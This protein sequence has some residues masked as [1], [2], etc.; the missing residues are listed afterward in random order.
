M[1]KINIPKINLRHTKKQSPH[2]TCL[3]NLNHYIKTLTWQCFTHL[4]DYIQTK[5]KHPY[6]SPIYYE[7]TNNWIQ[8][9]RLKTYQEAITNYHEKKSTIQSKYKLKHTKKQSPHVKCPQ[10]LTTTSKHWLANVL[11]IQLTI[12]KQNINTHM[13]NQHTK[14]EPTIESKKE[15]KKRLK[16]HQEATTNIPWKNQTPEK[17]RDQTHE[18]SYKNRTNRH[19]NQNP[20][21]LF[22]SERRHQV[23]TER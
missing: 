20:T 16:T 18:I 2:V 1:K 3:K 5:Y 21:H 14:K 8:K 10:N 12:S 9:K 17:E 22:W 19:E 6:E 23:P 15:M 4:A 7:R 13:N 11:L